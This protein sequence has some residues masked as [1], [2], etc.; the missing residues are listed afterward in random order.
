VVA[1]RRETWTDAGGLYRL[2]AVMINGRNLVV[3]FGSRALR[4]LI[5]DVPRGAGRASRGARLPKS[6]YRSALR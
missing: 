2:L 3:Q 4:S 6:A 5:S 1:P